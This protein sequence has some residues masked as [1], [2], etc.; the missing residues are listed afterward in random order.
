MPAM[1]SRLA[2]LAR[3]DERRSGTLPRLLP[4]LALDART[5]AFDICVYVAHRSIVARA[6][7]QRCEDGSL[8]LLVHE[9]SAPTAPPFRPVVALSRFRCSSLILARSM[10]SSRLLGR[11]PENRSNSRVAA[12]TSSCARRMRSRALARG[13]RG[14][15]EILH[16]ECS[17]AGARQRAR[18]VSV[19]ASRQHAHERPSRWSS[20]TCS[21]WTADARAG[22][23]R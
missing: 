18:I 12:S 22:N 9:T 16:K 14:S 3:A 11:P 7:V 20:A 13:S 17:K 15:R 2:A 10:K 4:S 6:S 21:P 5:H 23:P 1:P 8:G 19:T